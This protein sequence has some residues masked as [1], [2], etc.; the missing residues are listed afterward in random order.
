MAQFELAGIT[1]HL[2]CGYYFPYSKSTNSVEEP[3]L[4]MPTT[5]KKKNQTN[6]QIKTK[7][8]FRVIVAGKSKVLS[9]VKF[10]LILVR[11]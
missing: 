4:Y 3:I 11:I 10:M 1:L 9:A 2:H 5:I 6:K 7:G 8:N